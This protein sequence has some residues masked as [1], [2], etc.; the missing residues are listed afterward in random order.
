MKKTILFLSAALVAL[1]FA[2]CGGQGGN[3]ESGEDS[4]AATAQQDTT[5]VAETAPEAEAV[6]AEPVLNASLLGKYSNNNDPTI[7]LQVSDKYGTYN[8]NKGYGYVQAANE[9]YEYDFNLVITS[10]TPD[11]DNIKVHY[12]KMESYCEGDPDDM[13]GEDA[14]EWVTQKVGEGDLTIIPAGAGKIK[15]DSKEKRI[16]GKVLSKV[17]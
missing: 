2:A 11:G 7:D 12:N 14:G 8:D 15:I 10:V 9:F 5:A 13:G 17:K 3:N 6:E 1:T 16:N 4:L